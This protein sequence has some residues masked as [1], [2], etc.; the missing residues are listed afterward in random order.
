M[1]RAG[2][3]LICL[4]TLCACQGSGDGFYVGGAAGVDKAERAR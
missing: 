4:L 3:A 1:T 2:L